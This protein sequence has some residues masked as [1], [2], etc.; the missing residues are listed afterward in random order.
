MTVDKKYV[1]KYD[2]EVGQY[3][4]PKGWPVEPKKETAAAVE[5]DE[6]KQKSSEE[7]KETA[8]AK[9]PAEQKEAPQ[10]PVEQKPVK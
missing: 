5:S 4:P 7:V 2:A 9:K 10:K 1:I 8:D 6:A 3:V